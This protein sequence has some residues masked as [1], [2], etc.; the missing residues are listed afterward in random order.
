MRKYLKRLSAMLLALSLV[1]NCQTP[2]AFAQRPEDSIAASPAATPSDANDEEAADPATPADADDDTVDQPIFDDRVKVRP[3]LSDAEITVIGEPHIYT[4]NAVEPEVLVIMDEDILIPELDYDLAYD[5]NIEAGTATVTVTGTGQYTG[6][7]TIDFIITKS[8]RQEHTGP[9]VAEEEAGDIADLDMGNDESGDD[10][11]TGRSGLFAELPPGPTPVDL[12]WLTDELG[13]L[14]ISWYVPPEAK[15]YYVEVY[16]NGILMDRPEGIRWTRRDETAISFVNTYIKE[17]GDYTFAI[18]LA[19]DG[20]TYADSELSE[21]S[22]TYSYVR[23]GKA[24]PTPANVRWDDDNPFI[25]TW[26]PVDGALGYYLELWGD[27]GEG[28]S[29]AGWYYSGIRYDS[30]TEIDLSQIMQRP[31]AYRFKVRAF[32]SDIKVTANSEYSAFSPPSYINPDS[33]AIRGAIRNAIEACRY[34]SKSPAEALDELTGQYDKLSLAIAMQDQ[35]TLEMIRELEMLYL[36]E[37]QIQTHTPV[38]PSLIPHFPDYPVLEVIGLGL[39]AEPDGQIA[40]IFEEPYHNFPVDSTLYRNAVKLSIETQPYMELRMPVEIKMAIPNGIAPE[41]FLILHYN[42]DGTCV[43]IRPAISDDGRHASFILTHF[44]DFAFVEEGAVVVGAV[45]D[46]SVE[47]PL[48]SGTGWTYADNVYTIL[49]EADVTVTGTTHNKRLEVAA[50]AN[51]DITLDNA[52]AY[53][54]TGGNALSLNAGATARLYHIGDQNYFNSPNGVGIS[55]PAGTSL[56]IDGVSMFVVFGSSDHAGIGSGSGEDCGDITINSGHLFTDRIGP[57][58]GGLGGSLSMDGNAIVRASGVGDPSPKQQGILFVGN[59]GTV[60]GNVT[61]PYAEFSVSQSAVLTVPDGAGLTISA[62]TVLTN[63]GSIIPADGSTITI[64]GTVNQAHNKVGGPNTGLPTA[65]TVASDSI[66]L[67]PVSLLAATGQETEYAVSPL[68]TVPENGWQSGLTFTGLSV[69]TAYYVFARAKENADFYQGAVSVSAAI[70]TTLIDIYDATVTINGT[71]TYTGSAIIPR[72]EDIVVM[73]NGNRLKEGIDYTPAYTNHTNAGTATV[74]VWGIGKYTR[75]RNGEFTIRKV[76]QDPVTPVLSS[77]TPTGITLLPVSGAEYRCDDGEWQS[78]NVF[79]GLTP[80]TG[81]QFY[82]RH[83]GDVNHEPAPAGPALTVTTGKATL[84]GTVNITGTTRYNETL[85]ADTS[86]LT[87]TPSV[88]PGTLSYEWKRGDTPVS[89]A[90]GSTYRLVQ[91]DIGQQISVSVT[92]ANCDGAV[93]SAATAAAAKANGPAA[94]AASIGNYTGNGTAFTYTIPSAD[95]AEYRMDNGIWQDS[96]VFADIT[97]LSGHI[98]SIRMKE[99]AT[100]E[101][102]AAADTGLITFHKLD[103]RLAPALTYT[104]T[105]GDFPKTV[106]VTAVDGAEYQ[107]NGGG[108]QAANTYVSNHGEEVVLMIR[109]EATGTHNASPA[110]IVTVSTANPKITDN[111]SS[112]SSD[113]DDSD[114]ASSGTGSSHTGSWAVSPGSTA[115]LPANAARPLISQPDQNGDLTLTVTGAIVREGI[116]EAG[117]QGSGRENSGVSVTLY[118]TSPGTRSLTAVIERSVLS[119]LVSQDVRSFTIESGICR[120][121]LDQKAIQSLV[122]QSAG[123]ITLTAVPHEVSGNAAD[124]AGSRP[125]FDIRFKDQNGKEITNFE[126]GIITGGI[127]YTPAPDEQTGSLFIIKV[128]GDE[129]QWLDKS[130]YDNG[131]VIWRS[132]TCS[133]Y[134][135]GYDPQRSAADSPER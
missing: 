71:Y 133:I 34:G 23:P 78:S 70:T 90:S 65:Q 119:E 72:S 67:N 103:G 114:R 56:T 29:T 30:E 8:R 28:N 21:I 55:V 64:L 63:A 107:F 3:D 24:M 130:L 80:N 31:G 7:E 49:D 11:R 101:A 54:I 22:E 93:T 112:D 6:I 115:D 57:G 98:F 9:S 128:T 81:Y 124:A 52:S 74:T 89:G 38:A 2:A 58:G 131:W 18:K 27:L 104:I 4:G 94:P 121:T 75:H 118:N 86:G 134:G 66:T 59:T 42:S 17:S 111:E 97:P 105:G 14:A 125:V 73:L 129:I 15:A 41:K 62:D 102:G 85:T 120:I 43:E 69:N 40:L 92:A 53:M 46:L 87:S 100:H 126:T 45:I 10:G 37:Y 88:T 33:Y 82:M 135:V 116:A 12:Q 50:G 32:S 117:K 91:E 127:R 79:T 35:M 13:G 123:N 44:S 108:Y 106:A 51:A 20:S 109:Q 19:G 26:S 99:T 5:N 76:S 36:E 47:T 25:A 77:K 110:S 68:Q 122:T 96:P 84:N 95:G 16:Q 61:V 39:N 83:M 60:Y 132:S 48:S 1:L 113:D